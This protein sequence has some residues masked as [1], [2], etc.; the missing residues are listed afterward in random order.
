VDQDA[1]IQQ[2][3]GPLE[4]CPALAIRKEAAAADS[5]LSLLLEEPVRMVAAFGKPDAGPGYL[6][7]PPGWSRC[8]EG[9]FAASEAAFGSD[10]YYRDLGQGKANLFVGRQG[11]YAVVAILPP[12]TNWAASA[13]LEA[14]S[15]FDAVHLP[16]LA[17]DG[18]VNTEWWSQN[19]L[20]HSLTLDL[21]QPVW[22][23]RV[24]VTFYHLDKRYYQY[25]VDTSPDGQ[26]W[27]PAVDASQNKAPATAEGVTHGLERRQARFLRITVCGGS[28]AA[29]HIAEVGVFD[30]PLV[31]APRS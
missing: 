21:G 30:D 3:P 23:N 17:I 2:L 12:P 16:R 18:N 28:E 24:D 15:T 22:V 19:G 20:P 9:G 6:P 27:V 31:S 1:R 29:A 14:T 25:V 7:P 13:Q 10:L 4:G 8:F 26:T 11:A 5:R